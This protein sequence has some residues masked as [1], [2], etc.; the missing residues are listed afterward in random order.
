M[1]TVDI[2]RISREEIGHGEVIERVIN[3]SGVPYT[4]I[5]KWGHEV[6]SAPTENEEALLTWWKTEGWKIWKDGKKKL[7]HKS[8]LQSIQLNKAGNGRCTKF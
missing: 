1:N 2:K 8:D 5:L 7:A 3:L 4:S 6:A